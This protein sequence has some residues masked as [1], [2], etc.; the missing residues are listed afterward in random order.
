MRYFREYSSLIDRSKK[1]SQLIGIANKLEEKYKIVKDKLTGYLHIYNEKK[2]IYVP[3]NET[4]FS[5]F[6]KKEYGQKFLMD[7]VTKIMGTFNTIKEES[8]SYIA[9]KNCLL[10][11]DTLE[12]EEF[13]SKE[14]VKFPSTL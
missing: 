1:D 7:E 14:F 9:F 5:A 2:G 10:D 13:T 8:T 3:Y 6:L 4:E 11:V 12:T